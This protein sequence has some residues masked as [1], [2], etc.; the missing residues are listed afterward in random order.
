MVFLT[1]RQ[2]Q[3]QAELKRLGVSPTLASGTRLAWRQSNPASNLQ[4]FARISRRYVVLSVPIKSSKLLNTFKLTG[5]P[6]GSVNA[7]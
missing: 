3:A 6:V 5:S 7:R 4:I 2:G 1:N